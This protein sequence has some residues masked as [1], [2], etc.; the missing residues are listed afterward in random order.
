MIGIVLW[1]DAAAG[2]GVIW[3]EDQGDLAFYIHRG[4]CEDHKLGI[5]DWVSFELILASD[6]RL[7]RDLRVLEEPGC[8]ELVAD[9]VACGRGGM[10][11]P[12]DDLVASWEDHSLDIAVCDAGQGGFPVPPTSWSQGP[13]LARDD[14]KVVRFPTRHT[15]RRRSA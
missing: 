2:K 15:R 10:P 4:T 9:L 6:L 8:P 13:A 12:A 14:P 11:L 5:G 1:S 7:A 3:C